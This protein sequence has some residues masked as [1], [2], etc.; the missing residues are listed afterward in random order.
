MKAQVQFLVSGGGLV[1]IKASE[2]RPSL[3][4]FPTRPLAALFLE[5]CGLGTEC[6]VSAVGALE[7]HLQ[8]AVK[9]TPILFLASMEEIRAYAEDRVAFTKAS[10]LRSYDDIQNEVA[11]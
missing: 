7:P 9:Q 10:L 1:R 6:S 8:D 3:V 5:R 11:P 2:E 4:A